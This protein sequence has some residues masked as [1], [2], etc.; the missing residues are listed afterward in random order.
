MYAGAVH[1]S[2]VDTDR[3]GAMSFQNVPYSSRHETRL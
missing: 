3:K 1:K 2:W